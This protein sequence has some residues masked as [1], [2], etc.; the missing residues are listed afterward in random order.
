MKIKPYIDIVKLVWPLALGMVN[1]AVMQFADRS[2]LAAHSQDALA[3]VL[4]AGMLMWIFAGFFQSVVGYSSVFV[5]QFHGEGCPARCR[6]AYRGALS[7]ALAAGLLSLP[8]IPLG[9]WILALTTEDAALLDGKR[10]YYGILM[11]GSIFA[12]GQMAALCTNL[13]RACEKQYKPEE[14][15]LFAEFAAYYTGLVP[16]MPDA[17]IEELARLL[18]EDIDQYPGT[19][20]VIDEN[21]DRGAARALVWGEKVAR[22]IA[23]VIGQ[24]QR[25]GEQLLRNTEIWV[26]TAC[27]FIY[28]GNEP[29]ERCPVCKVPAN[30]FE[31][32]TGRETA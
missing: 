32:C 8:L 5:A 16:Q 6:E 26:C 20:A 2:Y 27:G 23:S 18:Q 24:Y 30:R 1:T 13:A 29:P 7:L 12:Y 14:A 9:D 31:K 11:A 21:G 3:A 28:I 17:G 10:G 25:E 22:M 4:P 15:G 19:R